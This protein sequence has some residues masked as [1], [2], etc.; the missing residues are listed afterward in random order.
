MV[1][2]DGPG[3]GIIL[4]F[5]LTHSLIKT[6]PGS[7]IPGVPAS[8]IKETS[9]SSFKIFN[10]FIKFFVSLNLWLEI[11]VVL[12]SNLSNNFFDTLVSSQS[13]KSDFFSIS[14]ALM[15]I[16]PKFPIGVGTK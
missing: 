9:L 12:I 1:T 13:I 3:R 2:A 4:I 15:V 14:I 10:I 7:D 6:A 11:K 16:S 8:E 5:C